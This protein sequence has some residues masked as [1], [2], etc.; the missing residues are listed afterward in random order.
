MKNVLE[1]APTLLIA[2]DE[3]ILRYVLQRTLAAQFRV[4]AAVDDG[5]AAVQAVI[6]QEPDIALLDICMPVLNGLEA[7]EKIA[8]AKP[9]VKIIMLTNQADPAYV[10]EAF[11]RGA[12]GYVLK[13]RAD[14]LVAAIRTV[15]QGPL[16]RPQLGR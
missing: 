6:E 10:E 15:M 12:K 11:R 1:T 2:E 7:A 13:G 14:Q 8:Q 3:A 5:A 4:I 9:A 16:Y